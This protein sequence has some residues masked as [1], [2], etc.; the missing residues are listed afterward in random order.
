MQSK[1]NGALEFT[2]RP[3]YSLVF[4]LREGM[5]LMFKKYFKSLKIAPT[6]I[7]PLF[8]NKRICRHLT[9]IKTLL[10]STHLYLLSMEPS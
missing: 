10:S 8:K 5:E 9:N 4:T 7:D 6:A 1:Q 2:V 3:E